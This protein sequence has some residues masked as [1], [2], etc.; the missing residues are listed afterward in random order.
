MERFNTHRITGRDGLMEWVLNISIKKYCYPPRE[1]L[2]LM[3]Q[4]FHLKIFKN[5]VSM[6]RNFS[7]TK[8]E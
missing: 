6:N 5:I 7:Q 2:I 4:P 3:E 1:K 8:M